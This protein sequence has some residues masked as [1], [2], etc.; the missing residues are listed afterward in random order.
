MK[1]KP[2][3]LIFF[4]IFLFVASRLIVSNIAFDQGTKL[5]LGY[6]APSSSLT[7]ITAMDLLDSGKVDYAKR[8][9]NLE[10]DFQSTNWWVSDGAKL[11]WYG[12]H[13]YL[14]MFQAG[15]DAGK[16]LMSDVALYRS[17]HISPFTD[18]SDL[19]HQYLMQSL[20]ER[21]SAQN[22]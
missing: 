6:G 11:P 14:K 5:G 7:I 1:R 13:R 17:T 12:Y 15:N 16:H 18:T 20:P 3:Y 10:L 2:K 22:Q 19:S 4:V 8:L 21:N 9:L